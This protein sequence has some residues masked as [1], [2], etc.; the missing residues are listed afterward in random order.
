MEVQRIDPDDGAIF[1]RWFALWRLTDLELWPDVPGW[2]ERELGAMARQRGRAREHHLLAAVEGDGSLVGVAL[3]EVPLLD[4]RHSVGID[5]RVHPEHRREGIGTRLVAEVASRAHALG[6]AMLNGYFEVPTAQLAGHPAE[7][8]AR[9]QGFAALLLGNRRHLD[10]PFDP[11]RMAR[12]TD[13]LAQVP[14]ADAYRML[15]FTTPWPDEYMEDQC[16]M[17]RRMSTDEP[18]GDEHHEEEVWDAAR[19]KES[20]DLLAAQGLT[21]LAA[22]A[23]HIDS[24]RLVAFSEIV[25]SGARPVDAWQWATLVLSEH[26]GHRLGLAVKLANLEFLATVMPTARRLITGNAQENTPMIAVNDLMGFEVVATGTFWQK[27]LGPG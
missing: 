24:G 5:V 1:S 8:F 26:R 13:E 7:P 23:Q 9:S 20:D 27:T 4:N 21:K 14:G 12:L 15:T 18:S 11:E 25:V 6:R 19:V 16:E 17:A 22:V 3:M 10:L 2:D